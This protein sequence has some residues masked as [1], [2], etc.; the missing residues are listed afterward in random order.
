[1]RWT[2]WCQMAVILSACAG[3]ASRP[4]TNADAEPAPADR[5]INRSFLQAAPGSVPITVKRD[6]G[7]ISGAC[8][9]RIFVNGAPVADIRTAEKIVL[10]L[11][12][13][14]H[15][16]SAW[17]NGICS[18]GMQ[19]VRALVRAGTPQNYRVGYDTNGSMSL[20]PTAF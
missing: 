19:E 18:G 14:E 13:G 15:I 2:L 16:L 5:V 8:S 17:P 7:F 3:C 6:S 20:T 9:T 12:P 1:M 10:Q 4:M 11:Q